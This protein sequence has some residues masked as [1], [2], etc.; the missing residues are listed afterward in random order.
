MPTWLENWSL[1]ALSGG[2]QPQAAQRRAVTAVLDTLIHEKAAVPIPAIRAVVA[3][4]FP[5]QATV[6]KTFPKEF[7]SSLTR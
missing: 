2:Y 7:P 6:S 5:S 4:F 1:P 3:E